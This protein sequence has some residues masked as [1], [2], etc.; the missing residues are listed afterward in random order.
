MA[1]KKTVPVMILGKE[2]RIRSESDPDT[3]RRAAILLEDTLEKVRARTGTVDTLDVAVLAALNI[4]NH[5]VAARSGGAG[6]ARGESILGPK[7]ES[8]ATLIEASLGEPVSH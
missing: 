6:G 8:L 7:L 4:A 3:V 2:Y 1:T 5:L